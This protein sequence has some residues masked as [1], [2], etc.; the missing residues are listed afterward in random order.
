MGNLR[1]PWMIRFKLRMAG[2]KFGAGMQAAYQGLI[3]AFR[4]RI[5]ADAGRSGPPSFQKAEFSLVEITAA[6][7]AELHKAD[8]G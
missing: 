4:D 2:P 3:E 5:E 8:S 7:A 1:A 6:A